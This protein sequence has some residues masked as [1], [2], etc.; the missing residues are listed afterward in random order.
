VPGFAHVGVRYP[1]TKNIFIQANPFLGMN[2][3]TGE[4]VKYA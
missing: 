4:Q 3:R 1:L 2:F